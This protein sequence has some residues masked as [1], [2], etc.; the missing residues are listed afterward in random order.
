[1]H[2][3]LQR[4][5]INNGA[6]VHTDKLWRRESWPS[7]SGRGQRS[8]SR[9]VTD[10]LT[11]KDAQSVRVES[12]C[13]SPFHLH[14][15]SDF[16]RPPLVCCFVPPQLQLPHLFLMLA[17][18]AAIVVSI[19]FFLGLFF[20]PSASSFQM[21]QFYFRHAICLFPCFHLFFSLSLTLQCLCFAALCT[22]VCAPFI[23]HQ[24][25][26]W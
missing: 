7:S 22:H 6:S 14:E 10:R 20:L 24:T 21:I 8:W 17:A 9:R 11:D 18:A 26:R 4:R 2:G 23:A 12:S 19:L 3:S 1:M 5:D 15:Q 25:N 13:S 16:K